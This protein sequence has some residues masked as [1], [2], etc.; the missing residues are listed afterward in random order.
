SHPRTPVGYLGTGEKLLPFGKTL[1]GGEAPPASGSV[2]DHRG[3]V[4]LD[5][6]ARPGQS[7][8][9]NPGGHRMH[10]LD[11]FAHGPVDRLAVAHVGQVDHDLAQVL[12]PSATFLD[13]LPDV[14]HHLVGLLHRVVAADVLRIVQVLRT[15]AAQEDRGAAGDHG[16][17]QVVVQLLLGVS[18]PGVELAVALVGH[19]DPFLRV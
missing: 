13:Q 9:D 12:H 16:L 11:V 17:T 5:Q 4:D 2:R 1:P 19:D 7:G 10:A 6:P 14:L 3:R 15:L 8:H 18:V